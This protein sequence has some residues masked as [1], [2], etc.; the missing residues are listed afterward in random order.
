MLQDIEQLKGDHQKSE[1]RHRSARVA[2]ELEEIEASLGGE[3]IVDQQSIAM[4]S[5]V[6]SALEADVK[7]WKEEDWNDETLAKQHGLV[8][9]A[10][11]AYWD[12]AY[13]ENKYGDSY[14]WYGAWSEK[15]LGGN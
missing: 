9:Y 7:G 15:G 11:Q 10:S 1:R 4:I 12:E 13:T 5:V 3:G 14:D 6:R 2:K 8:T